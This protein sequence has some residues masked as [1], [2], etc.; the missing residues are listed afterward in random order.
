MADDHKKNIGH[1]QVTSPKKE[2]YVK[3][4]ERSGRFVEVQ[5][6]SGTY[7]ARPKSEDAVNEAA[8]K[9]HSALKR[10]ADR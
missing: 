7:R 1:G 9:R 5:T 2:G 4:D 8:S 3:R 10:L 6:E